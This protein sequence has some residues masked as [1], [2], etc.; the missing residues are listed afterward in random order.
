MKYH[1]NIH[2]IIITNHKIKRAAYVYIAVDAVHSQW[3]TDSLSVM[4]VHRW[5]IS[6][7]CNLCNKR[8]YVS[9]HIHLAKRVAHIMGSIHI[10]ANHHCKNHD[11]ILND[12]PKV[13]AFIE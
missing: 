10:C 5:T 9:N 7:P 8:L 4:S 3:V 1:Y 6:N 11:I 12:L 2:K 13:A